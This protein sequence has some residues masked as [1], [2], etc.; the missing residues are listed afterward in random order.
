MGSNTTAAALPRPAEKVA[1]ISFVLVFLCGVVLGAV[2]M[3]FSGHASLHGAPPAADGLSMSVP[4]WREKLDLTDQQTDQ[5]KSILDDFSHYY[6]NVLADGNSRIMQIL[7]DDQ[8]RKFESMLRDH[9][10]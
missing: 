4:E 7:N 2:L 10:K 5:L 9:R 8:K 6:D 3:S 1:I